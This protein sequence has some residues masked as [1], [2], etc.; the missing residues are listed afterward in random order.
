MNFW[1]NL[2]RRTQDTEPPMQIMS[3]KAVRAL[4]QRATEARHQL[5][6]K[7]MSGLPQDQ[8]TPELKRE[9]T[10]YLRSATRQRRKPK[11]KD[12]KELAALDPGAIA[13]KRKELDIDAPFQLSEVKEYRKLAT[14]EAVKLAKP[15]DQRLTGSVFPDADTHR[16]YLPLQAPQVPE[17]SYIS[18][19]HAEIG[20]KLEEHGYSNLD[21]IGGTAQDANGNTIKLTKILRDVPAPDDLV[22]RMTDERAK[23]GDPDKLAIVISRHPY[24]VM[25]MSTG[26]GWQSCMTKGGMFWERVQDDMR[27]GSMV[28]YLI[29]RNDPEINDPLARMLIKPV[30]NKKRTG[31]VADQVYGLPHADFAPTVHSFTNQV[32][33]AG[34]KRGGRH[35]L[36]E[37][38]YADG[39]NRYMTVLSPRGRSTASA[40]FKELNIPYLKLGKRIWAWGD[41]N[42]SRMGLDSLPDLSGVT[43]HGNFNASENNLS[44]LKGF[45]R[46]VSGH[47]HLHQNRLT[48]LTDLQGRSLQSLSVEQNRLQ[49]LQGGPAEIRSTLSLNDNP[50]T[51]LAGAPTYRMLVSDWGVFRSG[52]QLPDHLMPDSP[53]DDAAQTTPDPKPTAQPG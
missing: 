49:T 9:L 53:T 48:D 29:S 14:D 1:F 32:M 31:W 50:L 46:H 28:A 21:Y 38:L 34:M 42:L 45:P 47:V 10:R 5:V 36:P 24:D 18:R 39:L 13:Q 11:L 25:R 15:F 16:I 44:H 22:K 17:G 41:V 3:E 43:L 40:M 23:M 4:R 19:T 26:R 51:H 27:E 12:L 30:R 7:A 2:T 20:M 37:D 52:E 35:K 8:Q 6:A 33:N